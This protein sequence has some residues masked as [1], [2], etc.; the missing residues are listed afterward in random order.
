MIPAEVA[1]VVPWAMSY[2]LALGGVLFVM[3]SW[4]GR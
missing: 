1:N 2:G 4:S 3:A